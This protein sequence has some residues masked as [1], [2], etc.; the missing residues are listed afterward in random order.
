M[1]II[2][3]YTKFMFE[4]K[5]ILSY[6]NNNLATLGTFL[7]IEAFHTSIEDLYSPEYAYDEDNEVSEEGD[8]MK[9]PGFVSET[10]NLVVNEGETITL[11]CIVT[12]YE[13]RL[14]GIFTKL[15]NNFQIES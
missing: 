2:N 11:P 10:I 12:R 7:F 15:F 3:F 14:R 1:Y 8:V 13:H 6:Q 4:T 5:S 9:A